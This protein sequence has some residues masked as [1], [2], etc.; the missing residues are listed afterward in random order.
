MLT[1]TT[2]IHSKFRLSQLKRERKV[3]DKNI[4]SDAIYEVNFYV[5]LHPQNHS[6]WKIFLRIT[7]YV[8]KQHHLSD[9]NKFWIASQMLCPYNIHIII[10]GRHSCYHSF[11]LNSYLNFLK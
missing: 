7:L 8:S 5:D 3:F 4:K 10:P 1:C 9:N 11:W 2:N 6:L